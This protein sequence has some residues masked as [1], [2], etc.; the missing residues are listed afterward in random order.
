M[1]AL[2]PEWP[3]G[4]SP[5]KVQLPAER[6]GANAAVD[7]ECKCQK[8]IL[9]S[10]VCLPGSQNPG[11]GTYRRGHDVHYVPATRSS[12]VPHLR[13]KLAL[14]SGN[15][16]VIEIGRGGYR[17]F[18]NHHP[19]R[20]LS[21]IK[22]GG[23]TRIPEGCGSILRSGGGDCFSILPAEEEYV[24]CGEQ[25]LLQPRTRPPQKRAA[26]NRFPA[27]PDLSPLTLPI[28]RAI[29]ER[30]PRSRKS[31]R[32]QLA[33]AIA[34]DVLD[35]VHVEGP[36]WMATVSATPFGESLRDASVVGEI[37]STIRRW[38]RH[39]PAPACREL[40]EHIAFDVLD[41]R[42]VLEDLWS[43]RLPGGGEG[44]Q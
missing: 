44:D 16:I 1:R 5:T 41:A 30:F 9:G 32:E 13:G 2:H 37:H 15:L 3:E 18:Y 23:T 27:S 40:A 29:G 36:L 8:K 10:L 33:F 11:C 38:F 22:I 7:E 43:V 12:D 39:F 6:Q 25:R 28:L 26:E 21:I 20:L 34:H 19:Q 4:R 31:T 35:V 42:R 17:S 14:V 24:P